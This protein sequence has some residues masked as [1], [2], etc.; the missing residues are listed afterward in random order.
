MLGQ[1]E[2]QRPYYGSTRLIKVQLTQLLDGER[3]EDR[4]NDAMTDSDGQLIA[5][6]AGITGNIRLSEPSKSY[7]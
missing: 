5:R 7:L 6:K 3:G 4:L 2:T 1:S